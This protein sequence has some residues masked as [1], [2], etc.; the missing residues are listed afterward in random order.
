[1]ANSSGQFGALCLLHDHDNYDTDVDTKITFLST[2]P[3]AAVT[4]KLFDLSL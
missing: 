1:M 2:G 3:T 4:P